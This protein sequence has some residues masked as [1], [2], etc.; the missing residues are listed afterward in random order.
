MGVFKEKTKRLLNMFKLSTVWR[1]KETMPGVKG[2][3]ILKAY[4]MALGGKLVYSYRHKNIIVNT[5]SI[6]MARL[7]KDSSEP[8]NGISFLA[9]G[10]GSGEWDLFDPPAPTT[11]QT[12]LEYEYYR[13]AI[14]VSTFVHPETGEPTNAYTNIVDY[15]VTFGEGEA[16]GPMV[17]LG[18][19]GGDATSELN[20][21]TMV[22]WR[23]F[24]VINK[25]STM[26]VTVIFRITT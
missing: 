1:E 25:T 10:S 3:L 11:S 16:V 8:S 6:L 18:L 15:A 7:L 20:S 24:P 9:V 14:E 26:S 17:E 22:N 21:G 2:E 5:A 4:D 23:T 13:K 12:Q 19:F